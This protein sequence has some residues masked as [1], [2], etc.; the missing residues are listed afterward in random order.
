MLLRRVPPAWMGYYHV[1]QEMYLNAYGKVRKL[2]RYQRLK[3]R[4]RG[5]KMG[6]KQGKIDHFA[7][8][9]IRRYAAYLQQAF[10]KSAEANEAR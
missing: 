2:T 6:L 7:D 3:D 5:F 4:Y 10:L 1:G 8:H 9:A